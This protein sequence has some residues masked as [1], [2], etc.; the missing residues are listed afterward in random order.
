MT[1][2]NRRSVLQ[3]ENRVRPKV[4]FETQSRVES[5]HSKER[6]GEV[7]LKNQDYE[8]KLRR[9]VSTQTPCC[10]STEVFFW[11][12]NNFGYGYYPE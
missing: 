3:S 12:E 1:V 9:T 6:I 7:S 5:F 11:G 8:G 10:L 2:F 4:S